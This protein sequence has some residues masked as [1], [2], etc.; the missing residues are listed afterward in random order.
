MAGQSPNF[1]EHR[2]LRQVHTPEFWA[3]P[4]GKTPVFNALFRR[5]P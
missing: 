5:I 3:S 1:R 2:E 4:G